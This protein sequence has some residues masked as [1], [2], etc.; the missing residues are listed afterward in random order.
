M[1]M[2][3]PPFSLDSYCN[4]LIISFGREKTNLIAI[5]LITV[6]NA[7]LTGRQS[8]QKLQCLYGNPIANNVFQK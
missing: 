5:G 1:S 2:G 3:T 6:F 8:S 4:Q 7:I